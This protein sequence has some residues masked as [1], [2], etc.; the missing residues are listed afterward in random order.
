MKMAIRVPHLE[1][2]ANQKIIIYD[3]DA[4]SNLIN[5]LTKE[6]TI[7]KSYIKKK[8]SHE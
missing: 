5:F 3:A 2:W 4:C 8:T 6:M 7:R 1:M